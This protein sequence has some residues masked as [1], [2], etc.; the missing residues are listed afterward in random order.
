MLSISVFTYHVQILSILVCKQKSDPLRWSGP[1]KVDVQISLF[2]NVIDYKLILE[3]SFLVFKH[4]S[5]NLKSI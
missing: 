3:G 1:L 5:F 2:T 4:D